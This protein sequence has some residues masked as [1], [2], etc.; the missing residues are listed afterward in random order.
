MS[1]GNAKVFSKVF[2]EKPAGVKTE[3]GIEWSAGLNRLLVT[4]DRYLDQTLEDKTA[5]SG[6]LGQ[7]GWRKE[8]PIA[9]RDCSPTRRVGLVAG[10]TPGK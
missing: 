1:G 8:S 2:E 9:R 7:P 4:T 5:G 3:E 10:K 6:Q